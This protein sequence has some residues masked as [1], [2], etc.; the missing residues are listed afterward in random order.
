MDYSARAK[1]II[2]KIW[3]LT[4]ATST[5][6]GI[7]WNTPVYSSYD[8]SYNFFWASWK[9][10][11]HSKNIAANPKVFAVIYDS[12]APE[13]T[14]EGVYVQ[15]TAYALSDPKEIKHA[16]VSYDGRVNKPSK[17]PEEFLGDY[18]RRMYKFVP[19]SF[20]MNTEDRINGSFVDKRI[21]IEL[22]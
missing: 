4:I 14:G 16:F 1:E 6:D 5:S 2:E 13:G 20:W 12:T 15:G 19:A 21:E 11:R 18:P 7:P 8:N 9:D 3:Y 22:I 10:A 17:T